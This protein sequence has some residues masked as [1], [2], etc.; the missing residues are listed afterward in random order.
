MTLSAG[1]RGLGDIGGS[2]VAVWVVL[3]DS[4]A[5]PPPTMDISWQGRYTVNLHVV[6]SGA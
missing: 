3:G 5:Q 6:T 2:Q 4:Q 1:S